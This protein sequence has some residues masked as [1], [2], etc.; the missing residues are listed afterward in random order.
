MSPLPILRDLQRVAA[1]LERR[2]SSQVSTNRTV[3]SRVARKLSTA[4]AS[5]AKRPVG[6]P[7]SGEIRYGRGAVRTSG[8]DRGFPRLVHDGRFG[9]L[10]L[11]MLL[12]FD[13]R[14]P[15]GPG[16]DGRQVFG[17]AAQSVQNAGPL[18][19]L[20][21]G[22]GVKAR[23]DMS[24]RGKALRFP[25][26]QRPSK[27]QS[28]DAP[29]FFIRQ[30]LVLGLVIHHS[31]DS[32]VSQRWRLTKPGRGAPGAVRSTGLPGQ[33]RGPNAGAGV[34]RRREAVG[35]LRGVTGPVKPREAHA[36]RR[37]SGGRPGAGGQHRGAAAG[38]RGIDSGVRAS[39]RAAWGL[40]LPGAC[41]TPCPGSW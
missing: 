4:S 37:V 19:R 5:V 40:P 7:T 16:A 38:H 6:R 24:Q 17:K 33:A 41:G 28:P 36:A 20:H 8:Q 13:R 32:R 10:R 21:I 34:E 30:S 2:S 9:A 25:G 35:L 11:A 27:G 1:G 3:R 14:P 26:L 29:G 23:V 18:M 39:R 12:A 15:A 31:G 22:V